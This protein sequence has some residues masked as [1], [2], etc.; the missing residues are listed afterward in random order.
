MS[1]Q[2]DAPEQVGSPPHTRGARGCPRPVHAWSRI[3]PAHAG[4]TSRCSAR[5]PAGRDHPRT[6]GEHS[7]ARSPS[8]VSHGSPPHTR[9]AP[10][11]ELH[12]EAIPRI[13][14]A[15]AGSTNEPSPRKPSLW[16]T[17]AHA[18]STNRV[19]ADP[20]IC[21]D[22]PRTRGEHD[23]SVTSWCGQKGSPPHTR[24]ARV[25]PVIGHELDRITPAH[26]G[27][28]YLLE[29]QCRFLPDH[30]RTR[31]EH[32]TAAVGPTPMTGSPPHTRGARTVS[33]TKPCR[34]GSPPHTRGAPSRHA[35]SLRLGGITP[36]HA[37]STPSGAGNLTPS[38]DHPRTRGEH[39]TQSVPNDAMAGSPPHT[40]GAPPPEQETSLPL[41][42]TPAHAGSTAPRAFLTTRWPDH[43]RTRGEHDHRFPDF[44]AAAG[45]PPHTR[46]AHAT[47]RQVV[48]PARITPAHAGSTCCGCCC[49]HFRSDHPRTRGEHGL[50]YLLLDP[51]A[52]S[53]PHTRGAPG[54]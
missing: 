11:E 7:R 15:H 45:S 14:P 23:G 25:L 19:L 3:T 2:Y 27:S 42:I 37:G 10:T 20:L 44:R 53:P 49:W 51:H 38:P 39:C 46:G 33:S 8:S 36:A 50:H 1:I 5:R 21:R 35:P 4:S 16:I 18:G 29:H 28:T 32:S 30:P 13:T 12:I 6:R 26:A 31:G 34:E 52:G 47:G 54:R 9:G 40:R 17:P 22:H 41:R 48:E 24:G 43:P